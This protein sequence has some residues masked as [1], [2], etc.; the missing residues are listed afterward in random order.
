ML[1]SQNFSV[2]ERIDLENFTLEAQAHSDRV[3]FNT[4]WLNWDSTLYRGAISG[5]AIFRNIDNQRKMNFYFNPTTITL[6]DTVWSIEQF[7]LFIDTAGVGVSNLFISKKDQSILADGRI[8][9]V[10]GDSLQFEFRNFELSNLNFLLRRKDFE[11]AGALNGNGNIT[12]K[13]INPLFFSSLNITELVVNEVHLGDCYINSLWNNRRQSLNI[14]AEAQRGKLTMLKIEGDYFPTKNGK[15]DFQIKLDKLKTNILNPFMNGVFT[16]IRGLA[17]GELQLSGFKDKPSLSGRLNLQ[18]NAFTIDYLKTRYNFTSEVEIANNNFI[19]NNIELFDK[20]GNHAI[21]NGMVRTEYLK[22]FN[23]NLGINIRN[24][25]C[26]DT[27]ETDNNMFYG[28]AYGTG[29]IRIRGEP[30]TLRFNINAETGKNTHISIPLSQ[31]AEVSEYN[32]VTFIRSDTSRTKNVK[33]EQTQQVD[34]T[35]IQMDFNLKVTP[36]AEVQIIFDPTLG[37]IIKARGNGDMHL[38]INTLGTFDM[39]GEYVIEKGDYLFTLQNVINK[40]LKIEEGSTLRWTGDPFNA[41]IDVVAVYRTKADPSPLLGLSPSEGPGRMTVDCRIFLKDLLMSPNIKYDLYMPFSDQDYRDRVNSKIQSEEE[42]TKQFLALMVMGSFIAP[43]SAIRE[44]EKNSS[45]NLG[46]GMN[47]A[48]E[49][50]SNQLSNW[51]SQISNDFDLGFTYRPGQEV[52]AGEVQLALST[53]LLNDRLSIDGSI[54]MKTNAEVTSKSKFAGDFDVDYKLNKKGNIRLRAFNRS[55]D[56]LTEHAPN[57]QG[58]G[59]FFK[60]EFDT[61]GELM[62]RYWATLTGRKK[63]RPGEA[64]VETN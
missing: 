13:K 1:G 34:L 49:L 55:N 19:L 41:Y 51:L 62:D 23:L 20:D 8:S 54:D 50:L 22:N 18:K 53:Q 4:R 63:P 15:M 16:D 59:F 52:D 9:D 46:A 44:G 33:V 28:T 29:D 27:R 32:F 36:D 35:G 6:S 2:S 48:S 26:M 40:R 39:V 21:V 24:M 11:L 56:D 64:D 30:S 61:F 3:N 12:G 10:P 58:V 57:T 25:L 31:S 42:L 14:N 38:S 45:E 47:N 37:D 60:Q 5:D 17:S 43:S 7:S